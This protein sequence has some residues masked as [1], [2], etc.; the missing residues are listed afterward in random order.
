[1]TVTS[2]RERADHT[3]DDG[4]DIQCSMEYLILTVTVT[5]P[6]WIPDRHTVTVDSISMLR[7]LS[8]LSPGF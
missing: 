8:M 4:H 1:M 2:H 5:R 7:N 6:L 3:H